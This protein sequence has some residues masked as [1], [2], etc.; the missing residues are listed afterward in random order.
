MKNNTPFICS[1]HIFFI[2]SC[3]DGPL[4]FFSFFSVKYSCMTNMVWWWICCL[5]L[6]FIW[7]ETQKSMAGSYGSSIVLVVQETSIMN[8]NV[9]IYMLS[10]S[11]WG[12]LFCCCYF[13]LF[14]LFFFFFPFFFLFL[15]PLL[16]CLL[17]CLLCLL[18][19]LLLPPLLPYILAS[20]HW[21]TFFWWSRFGQ[22]QWTLDSHSMKAKIFL[23]PHY[24]FLVINTWFLLLFVLRTSFSIPFSIIA[25][26][27]CSFDV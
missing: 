16:L 6:S 4:R 7:V 14:L 25:W 11:V 2:H 20:L 13:L 3:I 26:V 22:L 17:L 10:K 9:L 18:F 23:L 1:C 8:S 27:I 21:R 15:S 19:L 24:Y 5:L 12:R